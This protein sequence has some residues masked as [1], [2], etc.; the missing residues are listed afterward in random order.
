MLA[1]MPKKV[2]SKPMFQILRRM[3]EH[4]DFAFVV[5][6]ERMLL[7]EPIETWPSCDC[8]I[9]FSS[10]GYPLDKAEV[11]VSSRPILLFLAGRLAQLSQLQ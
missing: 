9:A 2:Q 4:E 7:Q 10:A 3:A 11:C 1:V 5:L 8:L 6:D